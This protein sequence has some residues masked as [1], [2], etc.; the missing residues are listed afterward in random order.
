M[1]R[2]A[3]Q[4]RIER[5][6][7]LGQR[8]PFAAE[9][10]QFY[11]EVARFQELIHRE[12]EKNGNLKLT[13]ANRELKDP[14]FLVNLR[15]FS[16]FL[17]VI[18]EAG[19]TALVGVA[20][21]LATADSAY[22]TELLARCWQPEETAPDNKDPERLLARAFLQPCAE[23]V[24]EQAKLQTNGHAH[25]L[26]PLC[27][28]KP[29][30]AVLRQLGDGGHRSLVC[31]FCLAEWDFRRIICAGCG[32]ED[33]KNLPVYLAEDFDYVRVECC[34]SCKQYIKA[35]DLTKN[36]LAEPIVD[37]I[38]SAP[39]DLWAQEHGYSKIELNVMGM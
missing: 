22:R 21:R 27:G 34:D 1:T 13:H 5:A 32:E 39:L 15:Q 29:V 2:S 23:F 25:R 12:L 14:P 4:R 18:Q 3:W 37:E 8:L 6:Q 28:R 16:S 35:I 7:L 17:R 33:H 31:S 30:F 24:R 38:A 9:I 36:G 10:L 11:V 20:N 26:C 19:P